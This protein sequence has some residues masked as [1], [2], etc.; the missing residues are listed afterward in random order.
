MAK[1]VAVR[2]IG[3][4]DVYNLEVE[5][6][7]DFV[8][9]DG[10]VLHNCYDDARYMF[11]LNPMPERRAIVVPQKQYDPLEMPEPRKRYLP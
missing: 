8:T 5:R 9:A 3:R 7:H 4:S 6:T 10:V 1:V 11:M 2:S